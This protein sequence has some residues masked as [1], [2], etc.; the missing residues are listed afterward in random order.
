M[1]SF[2]KLKRFIYGLY[3]IF[4]I[5]LITTCKVYTT[6]FWPA[7]LV[8]FSSP[9]CSSN[10]SN[11]LC[12]SVVFFYT[13]INH[14]LMTFWCGV[15]FVVPSV[16]FTLIHA[17]RYYRRRCCRNRFFFLYIVNAFVQFFLQVFAHTIELN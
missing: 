3:A 12:V 7:V 8:F 11:I 1:A 10:S 15:V 4:T 5:Q 2:A 13:Y 16:R 9:F 6:H 17:C 14:V